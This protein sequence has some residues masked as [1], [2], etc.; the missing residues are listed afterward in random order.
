MIPVDVSLLLARIDAALAARDL[1]E[2]AACNAAEV[3]ADFIRD[4][5]RRGHD[6][7]VGKLKKLASA[8]GVPLIWL[9]SA[10]D[11]NEAERERG[12]HWSYLTGE[13]APGP[14]SGQ[15]VDAPSE[16]SLLAFWRSLD[17]PERDFM[18]NLLRNGSLGR[19]GK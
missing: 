10:V 9:A 17:I 6:P 3:G 1:S 13:P 8:L 4:I 16:L 7:A 11:A 18:L 12:A 19:K 5:R 15:F 2:R 14:Q